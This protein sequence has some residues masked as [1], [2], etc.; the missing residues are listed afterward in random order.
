MGSVRHVR[1]GAARWR[2]MATSHASSRCRRTSASVGDAWRAPPYDLYYQSFLLIQQW[3]H[4]ATTDVRGVTQADEKIVA[5]GTRQWLDVFAPSNFVFTNPEVM[6]RTRSE[7]G[8]NLLRG[9]RNFI[10]DA[11]RIWAGRKRVGTEAFQVGRN[12]AVTPG[13]VV[14][15]NRLI[16]LIQYAPATKRFIPNRC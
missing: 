16:E 10:E 14:F 11:E 12:V 5:F 3:W 2:K 7:A 6:E 9:A 8:M 13:K 1:Q 15:R 4:N